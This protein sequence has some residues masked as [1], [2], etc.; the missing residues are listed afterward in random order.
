VTTSRPLAIY[1]QVCSAL[2]D[3][4]DWR[5]EVAKA[6]AIDLDAEANASMARELRALMESM[7]AERPPLEGTPLDEL[8]RRREAAELRRAAAG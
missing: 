4:N 2:G 3:R 6:L 5:A 7:E 8:K 1:D